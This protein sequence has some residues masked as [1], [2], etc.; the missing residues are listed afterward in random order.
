MTR[1]N[2]LK[3]FYKLQNYDSGVY[4]PVSFGPEKPLGGHLLQPMV[5]KGGKWVDASEVIDTWKF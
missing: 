2:L 4:P 1:E 5:V 3:G